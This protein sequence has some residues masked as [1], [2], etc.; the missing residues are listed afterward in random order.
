MKIINRLKGNEN[1]KGKKEDIN[2][3]HVKFG[4]M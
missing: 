4:I 1:E 3:H 2:V